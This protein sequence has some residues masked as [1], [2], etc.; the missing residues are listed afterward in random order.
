VG[1][2]FGKVTTPTPRQVGHRVILDTTMKQSPAFLSLG[3][4]RGGSLLNIDQLHP[5]A[6]FCS[7]SV[8]VN[9]YY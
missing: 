6:S 7:H 8:D 3:I 1:Q 5:T 2:T 4:V 9:A